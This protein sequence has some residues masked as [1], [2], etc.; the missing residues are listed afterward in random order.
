MLATP[1]SLAF[2]SHFTLRISRV[3]TDAADTVAYPW[4]CSCVK[5]VYQADVADSDR[6]G[7]Y[8]Y[9]FSPDKTTTT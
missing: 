2:D 5:L 4:Y 8:R 1:E 3:G 6:S 7:D 9:G